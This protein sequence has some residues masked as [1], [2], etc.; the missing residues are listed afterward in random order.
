MYSLL[1]LS[2]CC[3]DDVIFSV[4]ALQQLSVSIIS[5]LSHK[6]LLLEEDSSELSTVNNQSFVDEQEWRLYR[7][8]EVSK[9]L[10]SRV[11]QASYCVF[12]HPSIS[13]S[14]RASRRYG[15]YVFN[16]IFVMVSTFTVGGVNESINES[17]NRHKA[18]AKT[19]SVICRLIAMAGA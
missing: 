7:N 5:E 15:F 18:T 2:R 19:M 10:V 8:I 14:C 3:F 1:W 4:H 17:I 13:V 12:E 6:E 9:R 11:Y 16:I